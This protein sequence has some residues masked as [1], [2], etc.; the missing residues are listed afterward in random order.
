MLKSSK[1]VAIIVLVV[2]LGLFGYSQY[3]SASKIAVII[4]ESN[5]IE[6]DE[7]GSMYDLQLEFDN[8]SVLVLTAGITDFVVTADDKRIGDGTLE[9]FILQPLS[10]TDVKGTFIVDTESDSESP[11]VRITGVTKYDIGFTSLEVP[12]VYYPTEDQAREFIRHN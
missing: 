6:E 7:R 5:L 1:K 12:F 4:T 8:P 10:K 3:A 11:V 2:G 9:P